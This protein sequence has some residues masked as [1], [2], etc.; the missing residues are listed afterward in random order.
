MKKENKKKKDKNN[1]NW[2]LG[3]DNKFHHERADAENDENEKAVIEARYNWVIKLLKKYKVKNVIDIDCGLG[4]GTNM[5]NRRGF[6]VL[7]IDY[8][9][10][11]IKIAKKR[12][13]NVN[14]LNKSFFDFKPKIKYDVC[15]AL[16]FIEHVDYKKAL[17]KMFEI[18]KENGMIY[19]STPKR[20]KKEISNPHHIKEFSYEEIK[21]LFPNALIRGLK[22][23]FVK[24][25]PL[26]WM[27]GKKL[28]LKLGYKLD[29]IFPFFKFPKKYGVFLIQ[30]RK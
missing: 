20:K 5:L 9:I 23:K 3:R 28:G 18:I 4:Y 10:Q 17:K 26:I 13:S 15:I 19:I 2:K 6:K 27:F 24:R 11:A 7:G 8:S 12:Y 30:E 14:F 29:L 22:H 1:L 25:R 21:R 16:D